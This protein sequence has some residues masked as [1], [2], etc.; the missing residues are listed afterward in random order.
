MNILHELPDLGEYC[1][2][3]NTAGLGSTDA[4][5]ARTAL[6]HSIFSVVARDESLKLVGMGRIIGDGGRFFQIVDVVVDPS[7]E[8]EPLT[9]L[10]MNELTDYLERHAPKGADVL[11]MADVP[12][13]GL[14]QEYGFGFT[15]P[16]SISLRRTL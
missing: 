3:R 8:S 15:Y 4:S 14:Y 13:V 11:L 10:M 16:Q 12:A 9:R 6:Q 1:E 7:Q 5:A 2:L